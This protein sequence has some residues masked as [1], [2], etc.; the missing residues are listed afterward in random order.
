MKKKKAMVSKWAN[1][2]DVIPAFKQPGICHGVVHNLKY[3][4]YEGQ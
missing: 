1:A 2:Q 3:I 4:S